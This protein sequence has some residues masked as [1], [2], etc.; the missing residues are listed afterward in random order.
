MWFSRSPTTT[1]AAA[2][3]A[4]GEDGMQSE[5]F[6]LATSVALCRLEAITA[7]QQESA[8]STNLFRTDEDLLVR[9]R[10]LRSDAIRYSIETDEK[11]FPE[12]YAHFGE[13]GRNACAQE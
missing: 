4:A 13:T 1:A 3:A 6:C 10:E 8:M 9:Y 2:A 5:K 12:I 11:A 7:I